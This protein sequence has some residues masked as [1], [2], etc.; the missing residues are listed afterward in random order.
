MIDMT[1]AM[2]VPAI[3][4]KSP[5]TDWPAVTVMLIAT[6]QSI[7]SHSLQCGYNVK[8]AND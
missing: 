5:N 2:A 6:K 8:L 4:A 3:R 1:M 7:N